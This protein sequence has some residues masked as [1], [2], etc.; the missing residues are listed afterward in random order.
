MRWL[1]SCTWQLR[2]TLVD[3]LPDRIMTRRSGRELWLPP[4]PW[5]LATDPDV[6]EL[7]ERLNQRGWHRPAGWPAGE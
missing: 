5:L 4:L 2:V 7:L 6:A 3:E 1:L